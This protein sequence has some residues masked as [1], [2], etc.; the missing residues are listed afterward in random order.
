[1]I[2]RITMRIF[3]DSPEVI[4]MRMSFA[5]I[6]VSAS[7]VAASATARPN[8]PSRIP[9]GTVNSCLNCHNSNAGGARNAFG[10]AFEDGSWA[11]IC[12]V[13]TDGDDQTNGQELGD[14]N[15]IWTSGTAART[16][17]I[18]NPAVAGDTSADPDGIDGAA[19]GEGEGEAAEGEGEEDGDDSGA[20]STGCASTPA[21]ISFA[22][23]LLLA[24][25]RRRR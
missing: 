2:P 15:C 16:T 17:D 4:S 12:D 3:F 1:M 8:F 19:E 6:A 25:R 23:V 10:S 21:S 13:D 11:S 22:A 5:L 20:E 14:P 24:L 7:F 18:S 9:N